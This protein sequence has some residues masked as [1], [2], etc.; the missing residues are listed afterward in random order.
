MADDIDLSAGLKPKTAS[1]EIDLSAGLIPKPTQ[2]P[3][4]PPSA[5]QSPLITSG[6]GQYQMKDKD[7]KVVPVSYSHVLDSIHQGHVFADKNTLTKFAQDHAA[8]PNN[9]D[10]GSV[11]HL[12]N[13]SNWNP[14]KYLAA[15]GARPIAVLEGA[16]GEVMK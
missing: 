13:M 7:G 8:D 9:H 15:I 2:A 3:A 12:K 4:T 14:F 6:E 10:P 16:G 1:P 5:P 11:E